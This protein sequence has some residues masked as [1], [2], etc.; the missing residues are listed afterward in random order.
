MIRIEVDEQH[1]VD[2]HGLLARMQDALGEDEQLVAPIRT[3]KLA[4]AGG[5]RA[6]GWTPTT[7]GW[8]KRA[9]RSRR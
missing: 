3:M 6:A 7:Q 5:L 4:L 2:M 9:V 8:A 1:A